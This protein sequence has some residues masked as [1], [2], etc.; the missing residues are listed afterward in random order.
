ML[1]HDL[2]KALECTLESLQM[3]PNRWEQ[4]MR[5]KAGLASR[6]T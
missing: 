6:G 3:T 5:L 1:T 2:E 4:L